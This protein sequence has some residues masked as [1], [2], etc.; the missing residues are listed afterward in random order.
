MKGLH[1][2]TKSCIF[3]PKDRD[4]RTLQIAGNTPPPPFIGEKHAKTREQE[5]HPMTMEEYN[6]MIDEAEDD[7]LNGRTFSQEEMDKWVNGLA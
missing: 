4:M 3:V 1:I 2:I 6:A 7:I 5:I